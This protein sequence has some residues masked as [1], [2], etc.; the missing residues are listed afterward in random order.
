MGKIGDTFTGRNGTRPSTR[1]L[2]LAPD[3]VP[4]RSEETK[5]SIHARTAGTGGNNPTCLSVIR[6]Q[7]TDHK[8]DKPH[9]QPHARGG[10]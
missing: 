1:K 6:L 2:S 10:N 7:T 4:L 9:H 3:A 5:S 8:A